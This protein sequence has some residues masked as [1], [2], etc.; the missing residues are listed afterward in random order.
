M[1]LLSSVSYTFSLRGRLVVLMNLV[2]FTCVFLTASVAGFLLPPALYLGVQ[3][4]LS[5]MYLG[6]GGLA[7]VV[8][9][10]LSN[11]VLSAFLIVTLPGFVFFP[12]ST[13]FLI[14]RGFFWGTLI[15]QE[16]TWALLIFLPTVIIEGEAYAL[17]A[18]AGT[19][20]G[21]SWIK[22]KWVN[23]ETKTMRIGALT[24]SLKECAS[25][26]VLVGLLLVIAAIVETAA[27]ATYF[28]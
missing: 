17:A 4:G 2:F 20:V 19:V 12:L 25:L 10:F 28:P 23:R 13:V 8:G 16:P 27:L 24:S 26:Y 9:I 1:S 14:V 6:S 7:L 18:A 11:L 15:S 22:P 5:E 3:P 21:A